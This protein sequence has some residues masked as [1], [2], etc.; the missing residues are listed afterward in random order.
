MVLQ[1]PPARRQ[2]PPDVRI[3][4]IEFPKEQHRQKRADAYHAGDLRQ[5]CTGDG[6]ETETY[7]PQRTAV[8]RSNRADLRL[9]YS[10]HSPSRTRWQQ[11]QAEK[12]P[13]PVS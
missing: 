6:Q 1:D 12:V 13:A 7:P 2:V 11:L 10:F 8:L 3:G 4:N 9:C 5:W